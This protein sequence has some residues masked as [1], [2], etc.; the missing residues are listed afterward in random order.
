M[1]AVLATHVE[2][3]SGPEAMVGD[4]LGGE[5]SHWGRC[6]PNGSW[7]YSRPA[8]RWCRR[9]FVCQW[10]VVGYQRPEEVVT[11]IRRRLDEVEPD[12][13]GKA[14]VWGSY[15]TRGEFY[16]YVVMVRLQKPLADTGADWSSADIFPDQLLGDTA[17]RECGPTSV[18]AAP[19]AGAARR[20]E[21]AGWML[22]VMNGRPSHH[23]F[24]APIALEEVR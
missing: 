2:R 8:E 17:P 21:V 5:S 3:C 22:A 6:R 7:S 24:G 9:L 12:A 16:H 20:N 13:G 11:L 23:L 15:G 1:A 10:T 18:W 4:E 19:C 14:R